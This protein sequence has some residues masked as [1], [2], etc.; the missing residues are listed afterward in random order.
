MTEY[1]ALTA[2][3]ETTVACNMRCMHCGSACA[4]ALPDELS[5][6]QA[7]ALCDDLGKLGLQWITLSGGEPLTRKDWPQIARR[8]KSNGIV[9]NMITNGWLLDDETVKTMRD[10][11]IGTVAISLDGV[12]ETHDAIRKAGSFERNMKAFALLKKH[13]QYSGAITSINKK[14]IH[15]LSAIRNTLIA[16]GVNAWQL[17][18]CIPMGNMSHHKDDLVAPEDVDG[19][20]DFCL[21]TA[22]QNKI[23]IYPADCLGYYTDKEKLIR[24][25]SLGPANAGE[26]AGCNAGTRGFGILHNGDVIGCTSIRDRKFIEGNILKQSIVELWN[27]PD[28]FQWS[29]GMK[30]SDLG[31]A[32]KTC[33]YGETCLG[34][35]PNTRL[36]MNGTMRSE[37]PYCVY[38]TARK[39]LQEKLDGSQD[40]ASLF[41]K[42]ER[43]ARMHSYQ[44]A[45]IILEYLRKNAP[46]NTDV[47]SLLGF[48]HFFLENY[49]EAKEVNETILAQKPDDWYANK[50]LGLSLHKMGKSKE[51]IGFLE[52]S[53]QTAPA[54]LADPYHDLAAVYYELG[55]AGSA[56]AVLAR[57]R[58]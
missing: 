34:G 49:E 44:E 26:W 7:L 37:N 40:A 14:N 21:E 58:V 41:K 32:C 43:L 23:T 30:K 16:H 8:L 48:T 19:I 46:D 25:Y 6:E 12:G 29:R 13:G 33:T 22:Q 15:E 1:K 2:V 17:Q 5:T 39:K 51:G 27:A 42:A 36:T 11:G 50:G 38:L 56:N 31:G 35:C 20:L 4:T 53:I 55:D 47:L 57:L 52:K 10:C 28:A 3:W 24:M 54:G 9:T 45:G 18:I